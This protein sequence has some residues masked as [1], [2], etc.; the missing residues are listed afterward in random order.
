MDPDDVDPRESK[1]PAWVQD[2]FKYLRTVIR[3]QRE[4]IPKDIA[5][6]RERNTLLERKC[7]ALE[8]LITCA[9]RG[10]HKTAAE[11]VNVLESYSLTLTRD[12]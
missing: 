7:G 2:R 12:E 11:V 10:G 3:R 5:A 6:V 4:D 1:L 8:E 9:A